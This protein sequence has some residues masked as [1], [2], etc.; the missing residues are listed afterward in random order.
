MSNT[1][2]TIARSYGSGGRTIGKE[3]AEF[4]GVPYY[5]RNIIYLASDKS[6]VDPKIFSE[7]DEFVK[8][9]FIDRVAAMG[10]KLIPPET[11]KFSS[12]ENIFKYQSTVIKDLAAR[13]DCVVIGR[14]A[15]YTLK[16]TGHKLIKVFIWAPKD[17][18]IRNVME[19]LSISESEA[20][21]TINDINRHRR[22]YFKYYTGKDWDSALNYDL[23]I[24]SAQYD[25]KTA[26]SLISSYADI[27]S[28]L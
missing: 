5:D 17:Y 28:S 26:V 20:E 13:G 8:P 6:G 25:K 2:I 1:I 4:R 27:I 18:C 24:N 21:K 12:R 22:E 15:N 23:C 19:K 16:D 10:K 11:R 9:K 3:L 7:N 14:C